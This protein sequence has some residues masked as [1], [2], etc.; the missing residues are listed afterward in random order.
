MSRSWSR[1]G[2]SFLKLPAANQSV[3]GTINSHSTKR[4]SRLQKSPPGRH[5]P[6]HMTPR[7]GK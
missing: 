7:K 2:I 5:L 3:K 6:K 1:C 4:Q